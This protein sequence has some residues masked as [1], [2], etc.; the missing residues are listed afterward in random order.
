M[1]PVTAAGL[2]G[3]IL[4][5]VELG[6]KVAKRVADFSSAID[7]IPRAFKQIRTELP[8]I[9][10]GL[11]R[12]QRNIDA[13][14]IDKEAQEALVPVVTGCLA[15]AEQLD[16]LLEKALP[17]AG[18][19]SWERKLK[20][21]KSLAY[22]KKIEEIAESLDGYTKTLVFHQVIDGFGS[23]RAEPHQ[24][25]PYSD[26]F[27][28]VPF[29]R[30]PS[31]VG[32]D[33]IFADIDQAFTVG[34]GSQPK[35]ALCG[36]GGIG[37]SQVALE[38][39]YRRRN[40][41]DRCSVFWVNAATVA[42][43]EE[44]FNR[45]ASECGIITPE[46]A[47][48]DAALLLK[49][50]LEVRHVSPW[51]MVVDNVDDTDAFFREKMTIGK[52]PSEC[53]PHCQ[54]GSL[55]FTTRSRD[56]AFD[57]ANPEMPIT[58]HELG[59]IEG[60]DLVRKR[61]RGDYPEN[62]IFELLQELEYIPL[63]ITQAIAFMVKRQRTIRQY[64]EQYRK[65]DATK[66]KFLTYEFSDHARPESTLESVAKTWRL[67]FEFIRD[68]NRRAADLLC[69]INFFQH[70]G[71]PAILLQ[72]EDEDEDDLDFEEAA[73]L[74]KA[75]SFIDEN[76]S[77]FSTHRLV[78]L[79][80]RWWLEEEVPKDVDRWAFEAL[81]SIASR[82]P[83]ASSHP[84][85]DYFK[86]GE[87]L[88]PHAELIL[89][90]QFKATT[91]DYE[92]VRAKLLASSGRYVHWNGNYDEARARFK[93]SF[94]IRRQRLGEKHVDTMASMGLLGWTLAIFDKDLEALSIL[95]R[96]VENRRQV[97]GED[98][99]RTIDSLSDLATAVALTGDYTESEKMQREAL[100]RSERILG[101]RHNDTL[102][103][104][105]HLAEVLDEQGK[106]EEAAKILGD[107]YEIKKDLLG[108]LHPDVLVSEHNLAFMLSEDEGKTE[109]AINLYKRNWRHKKEVLGPDHIETLTTACNLIIKLAS[110]DRLAESRELCGQCLAEA[111]NG[112]NK[113]NPRSQ[114]WLME[115][116]GIW[117]KLAEGGSDGEA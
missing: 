48:S 69:L 105:G 88:L 37:K 110:S 63:A 102:N 57:V 24:P 74:L 85:P 89:Q 18:D 91:E 95:K 45:I 115:I 20:A 93:Q 46:S 62:L 77:V 23:V 99:P 32:R 76:D 13:G 70:Q 14:L 103:C 8:S 94:E 21:F 109:E 55:L 26:P 106:P 16:R 116:A 65:S 92:L 6:A 104:M 29:D 79:A 33:E 84:E 47:K 60:L 3:A 25:P 87:I 71:I 31:F 66:A 111:S 43:F 75:F 22:D 5:F 39:C 30:N 108:H 117:Q 90:Y 4:Q 34:E 68:S 81:K 7:G 58:I 114:E 98:D 50:W 61:L 107:V 36:L 28:L 80:T 56:V 97:L 11:K 10:D 15:E 59:K 100:A 86:L 44:S 73:A 51:L 112:P 64:L 72:D 96:L 54:N 9:L 27:W 41:D 52:T 2:A 35:A 40:K 19:S 38:Y 82:F 53:I 67:S 101:L 42:R 1:D 49:N 83:E 17:I 78:Q 113:N 12:I